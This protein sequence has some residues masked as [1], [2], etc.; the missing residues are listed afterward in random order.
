MFCCPGKAKDNEYQTES[1]PRNPER[2]A[3]L[4][5]K[6]AAAQGLVGSF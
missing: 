3:V 1:S 6:P 2:G 5:T 4:S